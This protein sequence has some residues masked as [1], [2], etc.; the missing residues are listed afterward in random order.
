MHA[1]ARANDIFEKC[2]PLRAKALVRVRWLT[3]KEEQ[4]RK[5]LNFES[6]LSR[7]L[8]L[9]NVA[10]LYFALSASELSLNFNLEPVRSTYVTKFTFREMSQ[11][12]EGMWK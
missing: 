4:L 6:P 8:V 9:L 10:V 3:M 11:R 7:D 12:G 5:R 2:F 1:C